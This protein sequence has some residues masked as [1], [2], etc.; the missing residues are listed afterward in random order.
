VNDILLEYIQANNSVSIHYTHAESLL[1]AKII[2]TILYQTED[3]F[4]ITINAEP[5]FVK[6]PSS[7]AEIDTAKPLTQQKTVTLTIKFSSASFKLH[8]ATILVAADDESEAL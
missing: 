1:A 8:Q 6:K 2:Y 5:A 7:I 3:D 4:F